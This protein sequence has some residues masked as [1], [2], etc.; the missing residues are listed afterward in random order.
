MITKK[1]NSFSGIDFQ[2]GEAILIDKEKGLTSFR[3]VHKV[4]KAVQIKKVGHA[5]TLD[6]AATGLLI[7]CTGKKTKEIYKYQED[8]KTYTGIISIGKR[9]ESMDAETEFLDE[10]SI[11]SI[12]SEKIEEVRKSFLG[13]IE[14]I[15]PMYS[16]LKHKGKQLYKYARKGIVIERPPRSVEIV[17]FDIKNIDLPDIH[18]EIVCSK[19]TYIR[20]IADDFGKKL[21]CGAY[22]KELRRTAIGKFN[23]DDALSIDEF[24]KI[25]ECS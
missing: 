20:V 4:R 16:A 11:D 21:N 24:V 2:A 19:G 18:F 13:K 7:I 10:K 25:S 5:G 15:P 6:P 22:L 14:Q 3:I 12:D 9:T 17:G 23:V 8:I 1:T